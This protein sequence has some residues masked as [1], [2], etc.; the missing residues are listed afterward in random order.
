MDQH[1]S[2]PCPL[3][4]TPGDCCWQASATIH[5]MT[6]HTVKLLKHSRPVQF[7]ILELACCLAG[8]YLGKMPN[9]VQCQ[10]LLG[11]HQT[12]VTA[13]T[14]AVWSFNDLDKSKAVT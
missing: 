12:N 14:F 9:C 6:N 1:S 2:A 10:L 13:V 5:D 7:A 3:Q 8:M 11:T 4:I